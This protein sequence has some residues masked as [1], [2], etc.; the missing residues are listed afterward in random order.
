ME[1]KHFIKDRIEKAQSELTP[2]EKIITFILLDEPFSI[3]NKALTNT[4]KIRRK[5][6]ETQYK[7]EI[8]AMYSSF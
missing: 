1:I 2:Y 4:L 5:F 6:I 8:D 7:T 3:D